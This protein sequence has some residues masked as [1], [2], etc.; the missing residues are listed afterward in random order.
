VRPWQEGVQYHL[1]VGT[2]QDVIVMASR[3]DV[4]DDNE[5][6]TTQMGLEVEYSVWE[7]CIDDWGTSV[8]VP[9]TGYII[10]DMDVF[11][12]FVHTRVVESW[13]IHGT[14]GEGFP[15]TSCSDVA[16]TI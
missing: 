13:V 3:S 9:K 4:P 2:K 12:D 8:V 14:T 1:D 11:E 5:S 7:T 15:A 10:T 16:S 6:H